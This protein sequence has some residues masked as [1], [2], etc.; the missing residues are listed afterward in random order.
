MPLVNPLPSKPS[1]PLVPT[2]EIPMMDA[3]RA[4]LLRVFQKGIL[5]DL[6]KEMY[7]ITKE[8]KDACENPIEG[9]TKRSVLNSVETMLKDQ[10]GPQQMCNLLFSIHKDLTEALVLNTVGYRL[11]SNESLKKLFYRIDA[12]VGV[13]I[14]TFVE[15]DSGKGLSRH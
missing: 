10:K 13:Y 9:Q 15:K 3:R 1:Y 8:D 11:H 4:R 2:A 5:S 12:T 14:N 7:T 6:M